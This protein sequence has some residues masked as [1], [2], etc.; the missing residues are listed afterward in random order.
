VRRLRP[1]GP[2]DPPH[3]VGTAGTIAIEGLAAIAGSGDTFYVGWADQRATDLRIETLA[4]VPGCG[5]PAERARL[6]RDEHVG[7]LGLADGRRGLLVALRVIRTGASTTLRVVTLAPDG[8]RIDTT[9]VPA[10]TTLAPGADRFPGVGPLAV[11]TA[12]GTPVAAWISRAPDAA[13]VLHTIV[14]DWAPVAQTTTLPVTTRVGPVTVIPGPGLL[15]LSTGPSGWWQEHI[16]SDGLV[17][18]PTIITDP[19]A[20]ATELGTPVAVRL[21]DGVVV[22][23]PVNPGRSAGAG[24]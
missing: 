11:G 23:V 24:R 18:A 14:A 19:L 3:L 12:D 9:P 8:E 22:A 10:A 2:V 4:C 15:S 16:A 1:G 21:Q 7:S 13:A 5:R 6:G 17:A 20:F